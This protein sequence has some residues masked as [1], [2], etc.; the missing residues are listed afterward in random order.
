MQPANF[1]NKSFQRRR[2]KSESSLWTQGKEMQRIQTIYHKRQFP[3]LGRACVYRH[4]LASNRL[5]STSQFNPKY[6]VQTN[7]FWIEAL[8]SVK[9]LIYYP[10]LLNA[11]QELHPDKKGV[12]WHTWRRTKGRLDQRTKPKLRNRTSTCNHSL[13]RASEGNHHTFK[14]PKT[15]RLRKTLHRTIRPRKSALLRTARDY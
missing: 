13:P 8:S 2:E 7:S 15:S 1:V 4:D 6:L 14:L 9:T 11:H 3:Q 10:I 5:L 12:S